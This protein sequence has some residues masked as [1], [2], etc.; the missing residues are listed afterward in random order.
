MGFNFIRQ[1]AGDA[2]KRE[3]SLL[4]KLENSY[5]SLTIKQGEY[6]RTHDVMIEARRKVIKIWEKVI[7]NEIENEN[8]NA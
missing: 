8:N 7:E 6:I 1:W 4:T 5:N 2:L 3:W